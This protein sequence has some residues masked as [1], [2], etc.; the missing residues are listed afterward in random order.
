L[1]SISTSPQGPSKS[2]RLLQR[3]LLVGGAA[4][5]VAGAVIFAIG[6]IGYFSEGDDGPTA[7]VVTELP[8]TL[9]VDSIH[10]VP[11]DPQP[12]VAE[13]EPEPQPGLP[14]P[15]RLV[16]ESIAVD[17]PI[18]E[19]GMDSEG[20]PYVPLNGQDVAWYNFS[21]K[22]GAGSNAVLAGHINWERAPGVFSELADVQP[23]DTVRVLSDDGREYT[24]EVFANFAVDPLDPASLKVMDPTP[25]DTITLIT[26]GGSWI[27]DPSER[28]GGNYTN[29]TI[30]QAR[31]IA[32][33]LADTV[34][35]S[36]GGG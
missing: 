7:T 3:L 18:V 34:A 14:A 13:P 26:C 2:R 27:P 8:T 21:S 19:L 6:L 12:A 28:F 29:R 22:P 36:D 15:L 33:V 30:V 24:Y 16:I 23:G 35:S 1:G 20:I 9:T 32:S 10:A 17:A 11:H 4:L 25:E 31:L 5:F